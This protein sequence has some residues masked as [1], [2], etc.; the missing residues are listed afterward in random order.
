MIFCMTIEGKG[1]C[2]LC[3]RLSKEAT[4][5][6]PK[7]LSNLW[8]DFVSLWEWYETRIDAFNLIRC[9][10]H[11][12]ANPKISV[13]A[14]ESSAV[15]NESSPLHST[16][17]AETTIKHW[18]RTLRVQGMRYCER[19]SAVMLWPCLSFV[20]LIR[21]SHFYK[22]HDKWSQVLFEQDELLP[23]NTVQAKQTNQWFCQNDLY[24]ILPYFPRVFGKGKNN[25]LVSYKSLR[26]R[27]IQKPF[28]S[29]STGERAF[30][31]GKSLFFLF[32][33]MEHATGLKGDPF[34]KM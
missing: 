5:K 16:A 31:V 30:C 19:Y 23:S 1:M 2:D 15:L 22:R 10:M 3:V 24:V 28:L 9:S 4:Q 34:H 32:V 8:N 21:L 12:S 33:L 27:S 20:L 14:Q 29:L 6:V 25:N 11:D 7:L 13:L 18:K 26:E 17:E